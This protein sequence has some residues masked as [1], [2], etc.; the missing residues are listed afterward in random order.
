MMMLCQW[1]AL[2]PIKPGIRDTICRS[3]PATD[4]ARWTDCCTAGVECCRRQIQ[5]QRRLGNRTMTSHG[6]D[7]AADKCEMTWDGY[8]CW[9][10]VPAGFRETQPC[11]VYMPLAQPFSKIDVSLSRL[12]PAWKSVQQYLVNSSINR[13]DLY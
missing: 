4:C 1:S 8:S 12:Y 10:D 7:D 13:I 11:P 2:D 3:M 9:S 5:R 6:E